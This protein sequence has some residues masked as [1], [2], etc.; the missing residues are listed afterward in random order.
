MRPMAENMARK[1]HSERS[2]PVAKASA[3]HGVTMPRRLDIRLGPDD[4][5][6]ADALGRLPPGA[7]AM[8]ARLA[9]RAFILPGGLGAL[10]AHLQRME[11]RMEEDLRAL[12]SGQ[13]QAKTTSRQAATPPPTP[14]AKRGENKGPGFDLM[15]MLGMKP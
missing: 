8:A 6:L 9:L 10:I 14:D 11:Q 13:P 5:D 12:R 1:A 4:A 3:D 2:R 15:E 7:R